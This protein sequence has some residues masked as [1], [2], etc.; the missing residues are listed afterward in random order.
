[1]T[2]HGRTRSE[3]KSRSIDIQGSMGISVPERAMT[4]Y[5][6]QFSGG[7]RH[8]VVLAPGHEQ[9]AGFVTRR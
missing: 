1:M 4:N 3:A 7:M 8:R 2:I 5:P 9:R 6:H